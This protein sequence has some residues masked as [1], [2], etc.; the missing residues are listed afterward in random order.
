MWRGGGAGGLPKRWLVGFNILPSLTTT[1]LVG[2]P[3]LGEWL[4][5]EEG[6]GGW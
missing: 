5:G 4:E 3:V 2:M 1:T 6:R